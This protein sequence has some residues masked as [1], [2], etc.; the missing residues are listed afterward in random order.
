MIKRKGMLALNLSPIA[1]TIAGLMLAGITAITTPIYLQQQYEDY[2]EEEMTKVG[3]MLDGIM[4][5]GGFINSTTAPCSTAQTTVGLSAASLNE[6]V[7]FTNFQLT[8]L[9]LG[10]DNSDG[11][12]SYYNILQRYK[13]ATVYFKEDTTDNTA[14]YMFIDASTL[15]D[16]KTPYVN[17]RSIAYYI[18]TTYPVEL[19][20]IDYDS[21]TIDTTGD[22]TTQDGK[23]RFYFET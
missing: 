15:D 4:Q 20:S 7:N 2:F 12:M 5:V 23:I 8:D 11:T 17:E 16:T 13:G 6:C 14:F 9:D 21:D 19:K 3:Y 1:I 18:K 10:D 22:G